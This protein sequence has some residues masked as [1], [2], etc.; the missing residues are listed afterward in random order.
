MFDWMVFEDGAVR[1]DI[2][3]A[4]DVM[5]HDT[6]HTDDTTTTHWSLC[7]RLDNETD[8]E[9]SGYGTE[10]DAIKAMK[11]ALGLIHQGPA[12]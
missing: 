12:Q 7:F 6:H 1:A 10:A 9:T 5:R 11:S 4:V 3:R 8:W 2:V